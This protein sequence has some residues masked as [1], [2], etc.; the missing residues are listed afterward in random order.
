MAISFHS[1]DVPEHVPSS[2]RL[3][4]FSSRNFEPQLHLDSIP[5]EPSSGPSG[6]P[7]DLGLGLS[8][9]TSDLGEMLLPIFHGECDASF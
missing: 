1:N 8:T 9:F 4:W 2:V 3:Q 7:V 6:S 5:F